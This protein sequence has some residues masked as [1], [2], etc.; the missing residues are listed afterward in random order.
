MTF[1]IDSIVFLSSGAI[2]YTNVEI[3][4]RRE[5]TIVI[6][7]PVAGQVD[8]QTR[9]LEVLEWKKDTFMYARLP[10]YRRLKNR[11]ED[12]G[13]V[14]DS[15]GIQMKALDLNLRQLEATVKQ[16]ENGRTPPS[17]SFMASVR[18]SYILLSVRKK[19]LEKKIG[20][21]EKRMAALKDSLKWIEKLG[22]SGSLILKVRPMK[23]SAGGSVAISVYHTRASFK[24]LYEYHVSS[25][26]Y[27]TR[28]SIKANLGFGNTN[29]LVYFDVGRLILSS[30]P[31]IFTRERP[32]PSPWYIG[33]PAPVPV[34]KM[35]PG[36]VSREVMASA[37]AGGSVEVREV[38]YSYEIVVSGRKRLRYGKSNL[39]DLLEYDTRLDV[40]YYAYP[41][42]SSR[43]FMIGV[44]R[45]DFMDFPPGRA[46]F[47]LDG[48]RLSEAHIPYVARGD[49][50]TLT[51]GW[52]PRLDATR[53]MIDRTF[54]KKGIFGKKRVVEKRTYKTVFS[55]HERENIHV[56]AYFNRPVPAVPDVKVEKYS[57]DLNS[58]RDGEN[59]V[60]ECTLVIPAGGTLTVLEEIEVSYPEG[61]KV[62]W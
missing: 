52:N 36:E 12:A 20:Q 60:M 21:I 42:L 48:R 49:V 41:R 27:S 3:H 4:A 61:L 37:P 23:G 30:R 24:P 10:L 16:I 58:C 33:T 11:M 50:D 14:L 39:V 31:G 18:N 7:L 57:I 62:I 56:V 53:K 2:F 45:N 13:W 47:Y 59:G 28:I 40:Q 32:L 9:N 44:F 25:R 29:P 6:N 8:F 22:P 46:V 55:S 54:G 17:P 38:P 51:M 15:L 19:H 5:T 35:I 1:L 26:D 43:I 34:K